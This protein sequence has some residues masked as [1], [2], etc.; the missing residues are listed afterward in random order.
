VVFSWSAPGG[1]LPG[2]SATSE[3]ARAVLNLKN[4]LR[5]SL[6]LLSLRLLNS[7]SRPELVKVQF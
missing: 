4:K 2:L 5:A 6:Q 7:S 3:N 1:G